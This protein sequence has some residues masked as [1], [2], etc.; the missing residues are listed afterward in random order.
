M[1]FNEFE[2]RKYTKIMEEY[3]GKRRPPAH[4]RDK[5]DVGFRIKGQSIEIF[6]IRP[7]WNDPGLKIEP[8]VAKITFVRTQNCWK[9]FWMRA[10]LKWHGYDPGREVKTLEDFLAVVD[11]D[12][13][14]CFW[15]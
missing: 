5:L 12:K 14:G 6:E 3:I 1:A 8:A 2:T 13:Y 4:I 9:V 15:G 7:A 10:D 11:N